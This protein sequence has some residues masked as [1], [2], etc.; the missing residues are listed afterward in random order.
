MYEGMSPDTKSKSWGNEGLLKFV[1]DVKSTTPTFRYG[2]SKCLK[3][4]IICRMLLT[5][6]SD[7]YFEIQIG[8]FME[9]TLYDPP[10]SKWLGT[11]INLAVVT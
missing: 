4:N 2:V 5:V 6:S 3:S 8:Y 10:N 1:N 9:F 7:L 11:R